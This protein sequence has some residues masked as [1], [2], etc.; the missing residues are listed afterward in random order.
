M[1]ETWL[2]LAKPILYSALSNFPPPRSTQ[3]IFSEQD[4]YSTMKSKISATPSPPATSDIIPNMQF[5]FFPILPTSP[6]YISFALASRTETTLGFAS[7]PT[8]RPLALP[9]VLPGDRAEMASA[10]RIGLPGRLAT[11]YKES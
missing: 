8:V 5:F 11:N 1:L 6:S 3:P 9:L 4:N 10:L 7:E 2:N